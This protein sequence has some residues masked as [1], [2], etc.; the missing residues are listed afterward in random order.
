MATALNAFM[1][2]GKAE[3]ESKQAPYDKP[4][5]IEIAGLG[6]GGRSRDEL[7]QGRR[8]RGRQAQSRAR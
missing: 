6:L 2:I 8:R 5:W 4:P 3:G 7:D 1:Q